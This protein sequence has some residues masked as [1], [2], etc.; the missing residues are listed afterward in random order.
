LNGWSVSLIGDQVRSEGSWNAWT[1]SETCSFPGSFFLPGDGYGIDSRDTIGIPATAFNVVTVGAYVTKTSWKGTDGRFY[2]DAELAA[3]DI[4]SFSSL[5]PTRD[6]RVK[7]DVVAPGEFIVS[8]R[9]SAVA[10]DPSDPDLYHRVL[11]GTSMATPHVAGTIALMLQYAPNLSAIDIPGI[12]RR[13][14]RLDSFTGLILS[15]SRAW[16]FGKVD[17]RTATGLFRQTFVINGIP[18]TISVPLQVNGTK[19]ETVPG[20]SWTDFYFAKGSTLNVSF[21]R[22]IQQAPDTRYEFQVESSVGSANRVFSVNYTAQYLL[23]ANAPFGVASGTGW[24]D[25][26]TNATVTAPETVAAPG[27]PGSLGAEY[28]LA[29]WVTNDGTKVSNTVLMNNP[30]SLTAVYALTISEQTLFAVLT[31]ALVFVLVAVL[32]ARKRLS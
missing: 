16:G 13:T 3:G 19:T 27:I 10:R 12:L 5:G 29:Y 26:N 20:G 2:G 25:A 1:D 21:A 11:A 32:F 18:S 4:A 31:G 17:A 14:A 9:S 23:T 8:A 24:Y 22:H 28:V 15:G 6:G 30:E 7:P